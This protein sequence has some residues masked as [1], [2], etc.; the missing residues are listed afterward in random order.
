MCPIN[1]NAPHVDAPSSTGIKLTSIAIEP[2]QLP[3]DSNG[4]TLDMTINGACSRASHTDWLGKCTVY[5]PLKST[6][7]IERGYNGALTF[8]SIASPEVPYTMPSGLELNIASKCS[9]MSGHTDAWGRCVLRCQVKPTVSLGSGTGWSQLQ[10]TSRYVE[11]PPFQYP[12]DGTTT[13]SLRKRN[14]CAVSWGHSDSYKTCVVYCPVEQTASI[15]SGYGGP[16]VFKNPR[17][18][19]SYTPSRIM[20]W[21][22]GGLTMYT[23]ADGYVHNV[24]ERSQSQCQQ[25]ADDFNAAFDVGDIMDVWHYIE[26]GFDGNTFLIDRVL[27]WSHGSTSFYF[28]PSEKAVSTCDATAANFQSK[29][30]VGYDI[31]VGYPSGPPS[32]QQVAVAGIHHWAYSGTGLYFFPEVSDPATCSQTASDFA[33]KL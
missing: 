10:L 3:A 2:F 11:P 19:T 31:E 12:S 26:E 25:A 30:K 22:W 16:L 32:G 5:C 20:H 8:T 9:K 13:L 18:G 29:F 15:G 1:A 21:A 7:V 17:T 6:A 33:A 27:H 23:Y 14:S 4:V 24:N 28:M